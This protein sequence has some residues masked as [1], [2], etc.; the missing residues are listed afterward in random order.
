MLPS[1]LPDPPAEAYKK[2]RKSML[3]RPFLYAFCEKFFLQ[4]FGNRLS[5]GCLFRYF[6]R[7]IHASDAFKRIFLEG[8]ADIQIRI[9]S[10]EGNFF[11]VHFGGMTDPVNVVLRILCR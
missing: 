11:Q 3:F 7:E 9:A 8:I 1:A 6:G 5:R 4:I 10:S 2:G